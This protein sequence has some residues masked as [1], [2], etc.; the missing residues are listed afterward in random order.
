MR[1]PSCGK[2]VSFD[3][4]VEPEETGDPEYDGT[5]LTVE[6]RRV[7]TCAECG[8]ELK[9][10]SF[11]LQC[12]VQIDHTEEC[13][14]SGRMAEME[15]GDPEP[16]YS[17]SLSY[18]STVRVQQKDRHGKPIRNPRY[19]RTY[20]G[21]EADGEVECERCHQ[22][23]PVMMADELQASGFEELV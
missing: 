5:T 16:D 19:Q 10:A 17:T 6:V 1:C 14:D 9:E 3:V 18:S 15:G 7:L 20:Y 2:F 23:A 13:L 4:D 11:E 12:D 8:D 21:V 22:T